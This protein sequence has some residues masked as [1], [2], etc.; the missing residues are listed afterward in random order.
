MQKLVMDRNFWKGRLS[1]VTDRK[2]IHRAVYKGVTLAQW[3][4]IQE[5]NQ[6][7][8]MTLVT[9]KEDGSP[10]RVLDCG[11]GYGA[12]LDILPAFVDY[13]GVDI[14]PD[15]LEVA[16]ELNPNEK[17]IQGDL[18]HLQFGDQVFDLCIARSME[19]MILENVGKHSW[20]LMQREML[21]VSPLLLLLNYSKPNQFKVLDKLD[22]TD[23]I[24]D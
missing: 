10:Y 11:C 21:R 3:W 17:F 22:F 16:K 1:E 13:T 2:E 15:L 14:S 23:P 9:P 6:L 18:K 19:G 24:F 20:F 5:C 12:L 4:K 7:I 8:L